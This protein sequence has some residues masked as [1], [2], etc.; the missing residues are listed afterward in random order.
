MIEHGK[1]RLEAFHSA[2][3][4]DPVGREMKFRCGQLI[5]WRHL[6]V[7]QD[8]TEKVSDLTRLMI[9]RPYSQQRKIVKATDG[10]IFLAMCSKS[11]RSLSAALP[12][13]RRSLFRY[14][15]SLPLL[16]HE[17]SSDDFSLGRFGS[18]GGSSPS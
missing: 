16:P 5:E 2:Y 6:L 3:E 7:A 9:P 14:R 8:L 11:L 10:A 17:M 4:S 12:S 18:L 1:H 15:A 13:R